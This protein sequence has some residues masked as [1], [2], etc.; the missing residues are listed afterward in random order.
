MCS[1]RGG[2]GRKQKLRI[3]KRL[4]RPLAVAGALALSAV[5]APTSH[6]AHQTVTG[7]TT[8]NQLV[9][10][11]VGTPGTLING[12]PKSITFP[13]GATD[14]DL[15]GIDYR[16]RGG[17]LFAQASGGTIYVIE[18]NTAL[19]GTVT[20][21]RVSVPA[22]NPF[23]GSPTAFGFDFNP[24]VDRIR[25]VNN[26]NAGTVGD[27]EYNNFRFNPNNG[28]LA[29]NDGDLR[30]AA[31]D[32]NAGDTPNVTGAAYTNNFDGTTSTT[33][34]DIESGNDVLA[35]QAPPNDGVLNTV[36][37]LGVDTTENVGFDIEQGT[38]VAY[39]A[40]QI[41]GDPESTFHRI[42]LMTGAATPVSGTPQIG[43]DGT[44]PL[45]G[46]SLVPIPV[47]RFA[48]SATSVAEGE[49][50]TVT[51]VREGPLNQQATVNYTTSDAG[52]S[53]G[54]DYTTTS[55]TLTFAP[56]DASENIVI[57]T[58]NDGDDESV[59]G[60]TVTLSGPSVS[61]N[62]AA[63]PMTTTVSIV[64]D[65]ATPGPLEALVS[66]PFQ[67]V[68]KVAD[69][70]Q[71]R[72]SFSCD[73]ECSESST[74][75]LKDGTVLATNSLALTAAGKADRTFELEKADVQAIKNAGNNKTVP[76][77]IKSLFEDASG[78]QQSVT[79]K[80]ALVR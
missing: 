60:I 25:T 13:A 65:E 78:N 24:V 30:F 40:L 1:F 49:N 31:A 35:T 14:T 18:P 74:L 45:E 76:L 70:R 67:T 39:A 79:T 51:V 28:A 26:A 9:Q 62:L 52:A 38:G 77:R 10:F 48:N 3:S 54:S 56:G 41:A 63:S 4:R 80:F 57:P 71:V 66:V 15:I 72:Y 75:E 20:A 27:T 50:A 29:A 68:K 32:A 11:A 19:A 64:D 42:N 69:T 33:L 44:A 58:Q 55:G 21:T 61:T 2:T 47:L 59:E 53:A 12:T 34:Y 73:Q 46:V 17:N 43:P 5:A 22:A 23:T 36:G 8:G 16:P 6:A 37:G 7:L